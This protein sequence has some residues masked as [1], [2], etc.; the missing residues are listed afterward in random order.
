[1]F[2]GVTLPQSWIVLVQLTVQSTPWLELSLD[3]LAIKLAVSPLRAAP[4][5]NAA[6]ETVIPMGGAGV[7]VTVADTLAEGSVT[8]EAAIVTGPD[9]GTAG[10]V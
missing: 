5:V 4:S 8:D 2:E 1:V 3:T 10:A 7:M 9:G 6:G